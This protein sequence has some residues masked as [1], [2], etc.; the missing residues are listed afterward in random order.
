M[1]SEQQPFYRNLGLV[2]ADPSM[3][4]RSQKTGPPTT[5]TAN[6]AIA[7]EPVT[8]TRTSAEVPEE[9][10]EPSTATGRRGHVATAT[11]TGS[12]TPQVGVPVLLDADTTTRVIAP[13]SAPLATGAEEA[14]AAAGQAIISSSSPLA[15]STAAAVPAATSSAPAVAAA[16][17]A[18][19][20]SS[21]CGLAADAESSLLPGTS[22]AA[23]AAQSSSNMLFADL[24]KSTRSPLS[25]LRQQSG[26]NPEADFDADLVS[27]DKA[28]NKEAVKRYLAEKIRNDWEFKWPRPDTGAVSA[29]ATSSEHATNGSVEAS[30]EAPAD[31][32]EDTTA[33]D[34]DANN[35]DGADDSDDAASVYSTVSEDPAHFKP[36]LEW[37]SDWSDDD[38]AAISSAYRFDTPDA[39]G[40]TVKATAEAKRA[41]IRRSVR[42][43]EA[44]NSGLA[45]FNAR[46]NAWTAAK[47]VRV[48]PKAPSTPTTP[49]SPSS[50]RLSFFRFVSSSPPASPGQPLSPET[51]RTSAD[52]TA[53]TSSDGDSKDQ[54]RV[55]SAQYTVETLLPL[56]PPLLPP[57]NPMRAS[58]TPATYSNLYDRI[59]VHSLTPACPVNL[60]DVL[61]SCVV[62]WKRDGEWPPRQAEV[63]V[64]VVAVKNKKKAAKPTHSRQSSNGRRLSLGFL[65]RRES[66]AG[67]A[68]QPGDPAAEDSAAGKG[69]RKSIQRVLGLGHERTGSNASNPAAA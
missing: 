8:V 22:P 31:N 34:V 39:V 28:K 19:P 24:Y 69:I 66:T 5:A 11:M 15:T 3:A 33:D 57:A 4:P 52:T 12:S 59:I 17:S 65:G 20:L 29:A 16:S 64:S 62:G 54:P 13:H 49:M 67:D 38:T 18:A 41:K 46:R 27:K 47:T 23:V 60:G 1:S 42:E 48:K 68:Q 9:T 14:V 50:R 2:A 44:W 36:R 25:R 51:T 58:I 26:A 37:W 55:S 40:S 61:R 35:D 10:I 7:D 21:T 32:H 53:V 63:P 56:A 30:T 45:C 43:E 6:T